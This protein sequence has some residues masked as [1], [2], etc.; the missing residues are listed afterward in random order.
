MLADAEA[1]DRGAT[2]RAIQA[3]ARHQGLG[4]GDFGFGNAAVGFRQRAGEREQGLDETV[5]HR[6]WFQPAHGAVIEMTKYRA[7]QHTDRIVEQDKADDRA[8]NFSD[9]AHRAGSAAAQRS[10]QPDWR[11]RDEA[12]DGGTM[13]AVGVAN[14]AASL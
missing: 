3:Q 9:H 10:R 6:G 14:M 13:S 7:D 1:L 8:D 11:T 4:R 2:L 5:S 12:A